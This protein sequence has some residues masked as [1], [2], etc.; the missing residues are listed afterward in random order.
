M[1]PIS[2]N[3]HRMLTRVLLMSVILLAGYMVL[4]DSSVVHDLEDLIDMDELEQELDSGNPVRI[5]SYKSPLDENLFRP[6]PEVNAGVDSMLAEQL[7]RG[8]D[9][10][11]TG[12]NNAKRVKK[13]NKLWK[14][15]DRMITRDGL[16]PNSPDVDAILNALASACIVNVD[17]LDIGEYESGTGE[18]W[19]ATLEGGQK[20]VMKNY[21]VRHTVSKIILI[22]NTCIDLRIENC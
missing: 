16:W 9:N 15:A 3:V 11:H 5:V 21:L 8:V 13:Y 6:W 18:K 2:G 17:V 22:C 4:F 12:L 1:T 19:L 10:C 20:A 7:V 14:K